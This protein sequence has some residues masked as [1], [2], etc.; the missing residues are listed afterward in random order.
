MGV[1]L[2][3][4]IIP[5][6][7]TDEGHLPFG[8]SIY[9]NDTALRSHHSLS[10]ISFLPIYLFKLLIVAVI[11]T[12]VAIPTLFVPPKPRTPPSPSAAARHETRPYLA[13]LKLMIKNKDYLVLLFCFA[14]FV[15]IFN[16][17]STLLNQ[18]V[19]PYGYSDDEAGFM[20]VAMI[21]GGLVGAI[22]MAIFVDKTK[23]HKITIKFCLFVSGI[24]YLALLFVGRCTLDCSESW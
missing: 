21:V 11:T 15:G 4:L 20:G 19:T 2:A 18:I 14:V 7:I 12:A 8:V 10:S 24:L 17:M 3:D 6:L 5:A 9:H 16:A 1:A 13:D 23:L 22:C